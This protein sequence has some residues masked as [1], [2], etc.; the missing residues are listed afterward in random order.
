[1][2]SLSPSDFLAIVTS[3]VYSAERIATQVLL[4]ILRFHLP[5]IWGSPSHVT[6]SQIHPTLEFLLFQSRWFIDKIC[7]HLA[8]SANSLGSYFA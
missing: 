1:M 8:M 3:E 5:P 2:G 6:H 4:P 7:A